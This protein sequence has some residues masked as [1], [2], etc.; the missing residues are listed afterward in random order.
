MSGVADFADTNGMP[1]LR[2]W[3]D[4]GYKTIQRYDN[5]YSEWLGVR[6]SIKMTTVKPSGTVSILAGESPGVH[7]TPGGKYFNRTIRFSNDDPML[8]LFKM[9]NYRVEPAAESPDTTSVV[10]FPIKSVTVSFNAE[11]EKQH[12]GTVLH[13]YDGQ[14]KT[15]SFLPTGNDTYLQ[16]PYTQISEEEY[17]EEGLMKLFPIDLT[18]VYAGMAADAIGESYCTTDACEVKFIKDNS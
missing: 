2:D 1:I 3:M 7:W 17:N 6:E 12:V 13:M 5:V 15:V 10:Y 11:T 14:L 8:P 16:M 18:G 4:Q 9:A